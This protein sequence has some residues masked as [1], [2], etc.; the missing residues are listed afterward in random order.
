MH[1]QNTSMSEYFD[2][3]SRLY[4]ISN[5]MSN[6]FVRRNPYFFVWK[7]ENELLLRL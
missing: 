3:K 7:S 6:Y 4:E 1:T 5:K 2:S